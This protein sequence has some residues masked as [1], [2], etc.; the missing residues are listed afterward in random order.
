ML[1]YLYNLEWL[2]QAIEQYHLTYLSCY[3]GGATG[4]SGFA[5]WWVQSQWTHLVDIRVERGLLLAVGE[6][7][8][9]DNS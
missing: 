2:S 9:G 8:M 3:F 1:L 7:N 4:C 5:P 6:R